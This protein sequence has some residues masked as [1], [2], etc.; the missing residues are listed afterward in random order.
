MAKKS[1]K[2]K[3]PKRKANSS[4]FR[5]RSV[6]LLISITSLLVVAFILRAIYI[7]K[8]GSFDSFSQTG[9][10][11]KYPVRGVDVSHHN[12]Y[13]NWPILIEDNI[14]F[15]YMK[16]TEGVDHIDSEY[17]YNYHLA[18]DAGLKV[19][20]YH[21][22]TFGMDGYEQAK[23]FIANSHIESGDIVPAIDVE[24]SRINKHITTKESYKN[25]IDELRNLEETLNEY[26]GVRPIIYTNKNCYNIYIKDNFPSNP[27]WICDL[28]DEPSSDYN[29]WEIW[30]FSHTG[31]LGGAIGDIDL[32]FY[33]GTFEEFESLLLP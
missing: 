4:S 21:F 16:S 20:T 29:H 10:E 7:N 30:Q 14:S 25:V 8:R 28:H 22:Y 12:E 27:L 31:S 23:H 33:R 18:K 15:V 32:N 2:R 19:G 11:Q 9:Y 5:Y 26:Y 6:V 3:S 24:H 17:Q 1:Y 13:I